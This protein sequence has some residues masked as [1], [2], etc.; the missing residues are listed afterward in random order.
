MRL[1]SQILK[2][3]GKTKKTDLLEPSEYPKIPLVWG[4]D[5]TKGLDYQHMKHLIE[6]VQVLNQGKFALCMGNIQL[7]NANGIIIEFNYSI[8][9]YHQFKTEDI[10]NLHFV[11]RKDR[12][13]VYVDDF[14]VE[15]ICQVCPNFFDYLDVRD[16]EKED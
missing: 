6:R 11:L 16:Y 15:A 8:G 3:C 12:I 2:S 14:T 4:F 9:P 13:P 7:L 10:S 1:M 5:R